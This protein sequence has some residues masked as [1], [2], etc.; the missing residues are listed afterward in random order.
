MS[1]KV[2]KF[3]TPLQAL[4]TVISLPTALMLPPRVFGCVAFVH[5]HKNQRTKLNP[6]TVWCLFLGYGLHQKGYRY[7]DPSN[8]RTYVMMDA[9]FLELET[10]Y[11]PTT[12]TSTLQ[13]AP[14]NKELNW[15]RFDWEPV[16]YVSNTEPDVE[17]VVS[18]SNT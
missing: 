14:Q 6:C 13:G 2:L 9:T 7:Y 10:F 8:H 15:L 1:S 11:S 3:K 5:L 18:V 16:V 12:S 17:P 4:S